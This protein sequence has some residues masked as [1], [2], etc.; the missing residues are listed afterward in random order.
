MF[1]SHIRNRISQRH[2]AGLDLEQA[3][4]ICAQYVAVGY[5]SAIS[6]WTH[7]GDDK[8]H[9]AGECRKILGTISGKKMDSYLSINPAALNFNQ[10]IF[11]DIV[12]NLPDNKIRI[13]FDSF[14]PCLAEDSLDYL[15]M[16]R[17]VYKNVGYTISARWM[18]CFDDAK[19]IIGLNIP[20]RIVKGQWRDPA[21]TNVDVNENFIKI[22]RLLNNRVPLIGVA[23]HDKRLVNESA[24]LLL[25]SGSKFEIEQLFSLP[26]VRE[27]SGNCTGASD[28]KVRIYVPYGKPSLPY[29]MRNVV[30]RP[31]MIGW[32]LR[33]LFKI[34]S[35]DNQM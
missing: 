25:K 28:I 34:H 31:A 12:R 26:L 9:T 33:D 35:G 13:H 16:A 6:V 4:K 7:A 29:N 21:D 14:L 19:K 27:I 20:V 5:S 2:V 17:E 8:Y 10:E 3:V 23:T 24:D 22:I 15:M 18:R 30:Q 1:N 11:R 32:F